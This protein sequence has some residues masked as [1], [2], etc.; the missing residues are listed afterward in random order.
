MATRR[1][2]NFLNVGPGVDGGTNFKRPKMYERASRSMIDIHTLETK[3]KRRKLEDDA[4]AEEERELM[5]LK[6]KK[7][8]EEKRKKVWDEK[9]KTKEDEKSRDEDEKMKADD[10][11]SSEAREREDRLGEPVKPPLAS[12]NANAMAS[13]TT[14]G[15]SGLTKRLS[16]LRRRRSM[17]MFDTSS[18]PPPYPSFTLI[19]TSPAS[20]YVIMPRDDEGQE[21]LPS[22]SNNI[23][24]RAIMPRKLEFSSPGVQAKDRKWRRVMCVLEGTMLKVYNAP[25]GHA[26]VGAF[27]EW[28]EKQVG[29]GD[30]SLQP[31]HSEGVSNI[32]I[33]TREARRAAEERR[34]IERQ[35]QRIIK[36]EGGE[37]VVGN[38]FG[39]VED[40]VVIV[41]RPR[42][43][44]NPVPTRTLKPS[45]SRSKL[46]QLLKPGKNH[47]RSKS[48]VH[49]SERTTQSPSPRP[50]LNIPRSSGTSTPASG[51]S[52]S[53][54]P[55]SGSMR[56][57]TPM[58]SSSQSIVESTSASG[59][60]T[61]P[62]STTAHSTFMRQQQQLAGMPSS[63]PGC[64]F[65]NR[66]KPFLPD[67]DPADLVKVYS[68]QNAESGIGNDYLK[69]RN[70]IRLR[71]EGEQ[72]LLQ[73]RDVTGVV[74][75]I[76][77]LQAATNIALDLDE[78]P[79]PRGPLFPRRRRRRV[80]GNSSS[81]A[82][83]SGTVTNVTSIANLPLPVATV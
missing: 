52:L 23:S 78:R 48:D 83:G 79:M 76:E 82:N 10:D 73:A 59:G 37:D 39:S 13:P 68:L 4:R 27:G 74:E 66:E 47:N 44:S 15:P 20:R 7:R 6:Q 51:G 26:G 77:A 22:Y 30:V 62:T 58:S 9:A 75:W 61:T 55:G 54:L 53:P 29:A 16:H 50:S 69:R 3:E 21:Q 40:D 45:R 70:V 14:E 38:A 2:T 43:E 32:Q 34:E 17:P 33:E 67:P 41:E 31:S 42:E 28:W 57:P 80:P 25:R 19:H 5:K 35:I 64:L 1:S 65:T 8:N 60:T 24:L 18:E 56:A 12:K 11:T 71:L 36:M 46:T 81:G 63:T 49:Q 72:F